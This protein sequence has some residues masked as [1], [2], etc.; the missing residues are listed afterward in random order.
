MADETKERIFQWLGNFTTSAEAP[1][2]Y[3]PVFKNKKIFEVLTKK[4][5]KRVL[6]IG[7]GTCKSEQKILK[8]LKFKN[9]SLFSCDV[10]KPKV[11]ETEVVKTITWI[12]GKISEDQVFKFSHKF[13]I[14]ICLA[15]SRYFKNPFNLLTNL[16]KHLKKNAVIIFDFYYL[17]PVRQKAVN[18]MNNWLLSEWKKD[19]KNA[20]KKL[21]TLSFISKEL[22][23][24]AKNSKIVVK[25]QISEL[26]IFKGESNI[27]SII[28]ESIF[29]FWSRE[30]ASLKKVSA[31]LTWQFLSIGNDTSKMK[32]TN[33]S[34]KNHIKIVSLEQIS[35]D[36][37]ILI[38]LN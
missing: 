7:G 20:Q 36:T 17:P 22:A 30:N 26:G 15:T 37:N 3:L 2:K 4:E 29:P 24:L 16:R 34:K 14:L 13:D 28:Y 18:V 11:Y 38:G 31:L 8:T 33:Y 27:Q 1:D 21:L 32:I 5:I 23:R 35:K 19:E 12:E 25:D 10:V 6:I 9:L